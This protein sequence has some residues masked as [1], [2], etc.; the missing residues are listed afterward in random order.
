MFLSKTRRLL[1]IS[2]SRPLV[3]GLPSRAF[4]VSRAARQ[5]DTKN[6]N[7]LLLS[8]H[9]ASVLKYWHMSSGLL[10]AAFPVAMVL[11]PSKVV[12]PIDLGLAVALPFHM[13]VGMMGIVSDYVPPAMRT[14][15]RAGMTGVT[16]VSTLGL[17]RLALGP[18]L[19]E[20]VKAVWRKKETKRD[21]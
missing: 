10:I 13:H 18:G 15:A 11:S 2:R 20:S 8:D 21:E 1:A 7:P 9:N 5:V 16:V 19:T 17:I 12:L 14:M 3:P 4:R 6:G